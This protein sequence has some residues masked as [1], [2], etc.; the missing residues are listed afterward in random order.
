MFLQEVIFYAVWLLVYIFLGKMVI[1]D[2]YIDNKKVKGLF[3]IFWCP[4]LIAMII[5]QL[6]EELIDWVR[7]KINIKK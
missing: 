7:I 6:I 2:L 4:L 5:L 1:D 3:W